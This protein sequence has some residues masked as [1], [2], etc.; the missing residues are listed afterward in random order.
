MNFKQRTAAVLAKIDFIRNAVEEKV[1]LS[2]F[3]EKLPL[4]IFLRNL[5]G[6]FLI[7]FSYVTGW[8]VVALLGILSVYLK[9]PLIVLIGGPVAYGFSHL[10]FWIGMFITGSYYSMIFLKWAVRIA[11]E[12]IAGREEMIRAIELYR[13]NHDG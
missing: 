10:V 1:D 7:L 5:F 6:V 13:L 2:A 11:V 8:P 4:H 9:E 3:T 12:K